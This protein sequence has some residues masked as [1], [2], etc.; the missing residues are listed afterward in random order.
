MRGERRQPSPTQTGA[1]A[2]A[3]GAILAAIHPR[4]PM[5]TLEEQQAERLAM[6]KEDTR[7]R[8]LMAEMTAEQLEGHKQLVASVQ[9]KLPE[10]E[11]SATAAKAH[12]DAAHETLAKLERGE[13]TPVSRPL[14]AA[15]IAKALGWTKAD[16]RHPKQ[17]G[18]IEQLGGW[19]ALIDAL[20]ADHERR[21]RV[22]TRAVLRQLLVSRD[23]A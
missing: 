17:L 14:S 15:Q 20:G 23:G 11:A 22:V 9:R 12:A 7:Q 5:P 3:Q 2:A 13:D 19:D 16:Q 10:I 1:S 4:I 21:R 6:V 8:S 18:E